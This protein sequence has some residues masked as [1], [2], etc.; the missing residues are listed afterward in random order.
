[1]EVR[2]EA[3]TYIK[4][5]GEVVARGTS[6]SKIKFTSSKDTRQRMTGVTYG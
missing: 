6:S 4:V 2:F 5:N 1:M 3:D